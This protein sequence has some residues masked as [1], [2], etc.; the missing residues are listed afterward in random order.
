[1]SC[2]TLIDNLT[3]EQ[4][5]K[6]DKELSIRIEPTKYNNSV[7]FLYPHK[8]FDDYVILPFA[9]AY[10]QLNLK[11]PERKD[12]SKIDV[13][14]EGTLRDEQKI[15]KKE[16][17]DILNKTGSVII[18]AYQSFGKTA[19]S[20]NIACSIKLKTLIVVNKII[21]IKQWKES[22]LKFAPMA[23]VQIVDTKCDFN[24]DCDFYIINGQNICKKSYDFFN[25]IG[26][27]IVDELHLLTAEK[28]SE[29]MT[30]VYPRYLIGLSATAY[31]N[32]EMDVL[33]PLFYGDTKI[34]REISQKHIVY[35]VVT[36][37]EMKGEIT[38]SGKMNWSSILDSQ[39]DNE[40]RNQLIINIVKHFKDRNFL[41]LVKRVKQGK[42]L[43]DKLIEENE[44]VTSLLGSNQT[45]D[46]DARILIGTGQKISTGFDHP[47]M[48]TL[49]LAVD[50]RDYFSQTL[51]RVF[52]R[53]D[54]EPIIFD[55]LDK[56]PI[57]F[58]H[59]LE[60]REIYLKHGG[61]IKE[62]FKHFPELK[63]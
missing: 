36:D 39:A 55:I 48:D 8:V 16:T 51:F 41:I 43:V 63:I 22:I 31:R 35:K 26:L 44:H 57:L 58:K 18:S 21:L 28:L 11:R 37:I 45:F 5:E 34:V 50:C 1:M 40:E 47:K 30:Y 9:Y 27:V 14:F 17:I 24:D 12:S 49:L 6:I 10:R 59:Y 60:R 2:K 13:K 62:F 52:R 7:R 15:V 32:D 20:I 42:L 3:D 29:F 19:T 25:N 33:I 4:K 56:N 53:R 54:I 38:E 61:V 23:L 46:K